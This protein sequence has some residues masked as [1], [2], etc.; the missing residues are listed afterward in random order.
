MIFL[1]ETDGKTRISGIFTDRQV[2]DQLP[3]TPSTAVG[4]RKIWHRITQK[5]RLGYR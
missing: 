1:T 3:I 4:I 5:N 2:S